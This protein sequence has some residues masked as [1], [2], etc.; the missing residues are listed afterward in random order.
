MAKLDP[1]EWRVRSAAPDDAETIETVRVA[2]WK[3]AYRG[4]VPDGYLDKL[5]VRERGLAWWAERLATPPTVRH[6][7]FVAEAGGELV[8]FVTVEPTRDADLDAVQIGEVGGVYVLPEHWGR[9]IGRALMERAVQ[10]LRSAGFSAAML[11]T[12]ERNARTRRFYEVAGW[13]PN[14]GRNTLNLGAEVSVIRYRRELGGPAP[15][16]AQRS[17]GSRLARP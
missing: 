15:N 16:L 11:W 2:T 10:T 6:R 8:G 12:L 5:E 14:G 7:C 4:I 17:V 13:R 3:H 9:G 1:T